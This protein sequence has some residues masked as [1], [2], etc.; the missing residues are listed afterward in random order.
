MSLERVGREQGLEGLKR[1][2]GCGNG[3]GSCVRELL[4]TGRLHLLERLEGEVTP[5]ELFLRVPGMGPTLAQNAH[6]QLGLETLEQLE[7]AAN[8]GTLARARGFGPRR[9]EGLRAALATMLANSRRAHHRPG[10]QT[11]GPPAAEVLLK[12]D[13]EYRAR[14][15]RG[16]LPTVTPARF[17]PGREAWLSV[18]HT[19]AEGYELTAMYSNS[20]R[21]HRLGCTRD[22]V[23]IYW[24][25]E[26]HEG[27]CTVVTEHRGPRAGLRVVRG[28]EQE[29]PLPEQDWMALHR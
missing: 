1:E 12:V 19:E 26:G 13:A 5:E 9:V 2:L 24:E 17:N 7:R 29:T 14:A 16:V 22:W 11:P 8:D 3:I 10:A 25:R 21:A 20:G 15:E 6:L 4:E 18:L 28:R 23:V 27:Q